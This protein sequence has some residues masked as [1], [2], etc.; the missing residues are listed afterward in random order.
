[1]NFLWALVTGSGRQGTAGAWTDVSSE[2]KYGTSN[3]VNF[4]DSTDNNFY[5]TGVQI[6]VGKPTVFEHHT[7][8]E[9][10]SL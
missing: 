9:E 2:T 4:Y 5:L 1:M 8:A 10:L 3:Q 6:E 7:F